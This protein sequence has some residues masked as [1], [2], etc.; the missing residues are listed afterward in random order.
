MKTTHCWCL[1]FLVLTGGLLTGSLLGG[2]GGETPFAGDGFR[3]AFPGKP[4]ITTQAVP[5]VTLKMW[6][7]EK[8]TGAF[9]VAVA[10]LP[11]PVPPGMEKVVLD[12]ARDGALKNARA[13]L[14]AEK[15][16]QAGKHP[17]REIVAGLNQPQGALLRLRLF[18]VGQRLYQVMVVGQ[19]EFVEDRTG[20]AFLDS[21]ALVS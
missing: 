21:F 18:L 5:G 20:T 14:K 1:A 19:A 4:K 2:E 8:K 10:N 3:V 11:E 7:V 16:I 12:K 15:D 13:E 17:G 6:L 9:F